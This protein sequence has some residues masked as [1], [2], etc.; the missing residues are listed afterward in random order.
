MLTAE[1]RADRG[2]GS[3]GDTHGSDVLE[4]HS[5]GY[6]SRHGGRERD[7]DEERCAVE[8]GI[9][10]GVRGKESN[11]SRRRTIEDFGPWA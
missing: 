1:L 2:R 8:T 7:M 10:V 6:L 4:V 3:T 5:Y 11:C 9:P